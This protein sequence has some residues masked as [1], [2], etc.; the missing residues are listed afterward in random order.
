MTSAVDGAAW[1]VRRSGCETRA[2]SPCSSGRPRLGVE[3]LT[4]SRERERPRGD[5]AEL[6]SAFPI[7]TTKERTFMQGSALEGWKARDDAIG[8][9]I[10]SYR[11][12]LYPTAAQRASLDEQ[13]G[14]A[15]DLYNAA[16]EQRIRAYREH[17]VSLSY[18]DQQR[19]LTEARTN[20]G[21]L[22]AG[23]SLKAQRSALVRLDKA[24]QAFFRRCAAGETPGFPRFRPRRRYDSLTWPSGDGA[25]VRSGRLRVMGVGSMRVCW[26][27]EIPDDAEV[28]TITVKR[29]NGRWYVTLVLHLSNP[30]TLPPTGESVGVDRG[31]TVPFAL[32]T[33]EH[34][35]GPRAQKTNAGSV[36]R[37]ARKVAR[38]QRGS[39]RKRKARMLLARQR[40]REANQRHDFLHKLSRRLVNENDTI[41]FEDLNV[42][43]MTRSARGTSGAPGRRVRQKAGLN[44]SISDQGWATLVE[45]TSYKAA[46]AGRQVIRV[47][48]AY[49]SQICAEC[50]VV[51]AASRN[52]VV[53][54]CTSCGHEA[55]ADTNAALNILRA[56]LALQALTVGADVH[57][58]A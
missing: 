33:G 46:E 55:H 45:M 18:Y 1:R 43:G 35:E 21:L 50:G 4:G 40:E 7:P 56:G 14:A 23:M 37:A 48:A 47:P 2:K 57:A 51:D 41:V 38:R 54:A 25:G 31:V 32:S 52:G 19:E 3:H 15:C 13:L 34:V 9:V 16:L 24:F 10:R 28:R 58:V 29:K 49:T 30:A 12:R 20:D 26:H 53:F 11:Y 44:R 39:S 27:R 8:V 6:R 17:G 22:P 42:Q 5:G 36:R